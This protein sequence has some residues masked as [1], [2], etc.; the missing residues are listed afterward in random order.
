VTRTPRCTGL[1]ERLTIVFRLTA[2]E[3]VPAV[4]TGQMREVDRSMTEDFS[5]DLATAITADELGG[6]GPAPR[7]ASCGTQDRPNA[8]T[9]LPDG[10]RPGLRSELCHALASI[11]GQIIKLRCVGHRRWSRL[12]QRDRLLL[13]EAIQSGEPHLDRPDACLARRLMSGFRPAGL[14]GLFPVNRGQLR[15][16]SASLVPR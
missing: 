14:L 9:S 15:P 16:C 7:R 10:G 6:A 8:L 1:P 3:P 4:S 13:H 2:G 5:I 11:P 12:W